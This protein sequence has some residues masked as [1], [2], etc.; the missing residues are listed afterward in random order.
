[1]ADLYVEA[2]QTRYHVS[3]KKLMEKLVTGDPSKRRRT[4][5]E[6]VQESSSTVDHGGKLDG[7]ELKYGGIKGIRC[8]GAYTSFQSGHPLTVAPQTSEHPLIDVAPAC[9]ATTAASA[10]RLCCSLKGRAAQR[11][12]AT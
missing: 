11:R 10:R 6:N 8:A 9:C 1:V 3:Q 4:S 7:A 2:I 12:S 5:K